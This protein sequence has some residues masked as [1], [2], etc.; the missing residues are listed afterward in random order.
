VPLQVPSHALNFACSDPEISFRRHDICFQDNDDLAQP[1]AP[2]STQCFA[3]C[4]LALQRPTSEPDA[5]I[6]LY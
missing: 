6:P 1:G 5:H 4:A 2:I 3:L